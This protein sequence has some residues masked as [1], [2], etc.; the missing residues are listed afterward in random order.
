MKL[1]LKSITQVVIDVLIHHLITK[2]KQT[3][4][5]RQVD[6][7]KV[8][9]EKHENKQDKQ[10]LDLAYGHYRTKATSNCY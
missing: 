9:T 5:Q 4:P 7:N 1:L 8:A 10:I 2:G 3:L 6:R